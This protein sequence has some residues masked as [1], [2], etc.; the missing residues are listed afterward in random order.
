MQTS[1]SGR[2]RYPP[3]AFW[4]CET[5]VHD[6]LGGAIAIERPGGTRHPPAHPIPPQPAA[7]AP[8]RTHSRPPQSQTKAQTQSVSQAHSKSHAKPDA[9]PQPLGTHSQSE[10]QSESQAQ[11]HAPG[12]ETG[13]TNAKPP[14]GKPRQRLPVQ[15]SRRQPAGSAQ[16]AVSVPQDPPSPPFPYPILAGRS[17]KAKAPAA[18]PSSAQQASQVAD[19]PGKVQPQRLAAARQESASGTKKAQAGKTTNA[20]LVQAGAAEASGVSKSKAAALAAGG[21]TAAAEAAGG[22]PA[23]PVGTAKLK[24]CGTCK[25]CMRPLSKQGCLVLRA[26]REQAPA[27][28]DAAAASPLKPAGPAQP[29]K[30]A[31]GSQS[32]AAGNPKKQAVQSS[33]RGKATG[34]QAAA[35]G[36]KSTQLDAETGSPGT[37]PNSKES[38]EGKASRSAVAAPPSKGGMSGSS[39]RQLKGRKS[40]GIDK[41]GEVLSGPSGSIH[42]ALTQA[43][44]LASDA[45]QQQ[46]DEQQQEAAEV[47]DSLKNS[48]VAP[49]P[50][51]PVAP[52]VSA[53]ACE[54]GSDQAMQSEQSLAG[55]PEQAAAKQKKRGRPRK[56]RQP[57][58]ESDKL[59]AGPKR[60]RGRPRKTPAPTAEPTEEALAEG[61]GLQLGGS[62][63]QAQ[64][65]SE[66]VEAVGA[67]QQSDGQ[68]RPAAAQA[69][70]PV[71]SK[72]PPTKVYCAI[73]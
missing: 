31:K 53:V 69:E 10:V 49:S 9:E 37:Q 25:T 26:V 21:G 38:G 46:G 2:V 64:V 16:P 4:M 65:P 58:E 18:A 56:E 67:Q 48:P 20:A 59:P 40:A 14:S 11:S 13:C 12:P 1:R 72:A 63:E 61:T 3:L 62:S 30:A 29:G 44:E 32:T 28:G 57:G 42:S 55:S 52:G 23:G 68:G 27:A 36:R 47:L 17:A 24:R 41:A 7:P 70:K 35:S 5:K 73:A 34:S 54:P 45:E 8:T 15:H 6:R 39:D 60:G 22:K 50:S 51:H 19:S 33:L 43:V 66:A 71:S